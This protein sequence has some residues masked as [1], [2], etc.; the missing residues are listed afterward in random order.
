[1]FQTL[2]IIIIK[3]KR[4]ENHLFNSFAPFQHRSLLSF[5]LWAPALLFL[6][7]FLTQP[8]QS[9]FHLHF[10]RLPRNPSV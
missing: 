10:S 9:G 2:K 8:L 7:L 1:M 3:K 6:T 4:Q 5:P